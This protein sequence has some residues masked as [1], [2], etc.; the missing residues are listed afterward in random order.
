MTPKERLRR[1]I[2]LSG[3][4]Y[5]PAQGGFSPATWQKYREALVPLAKRLGV[6]VPADFEFKNLPGKY[7]K[8]VS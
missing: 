1:A 2:T 6:G 3:P 4:D 5:Q 8:G 7:K